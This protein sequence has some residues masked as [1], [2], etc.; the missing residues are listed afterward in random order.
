MFSELTVEENLKIGLMTRNNG[1][2][3]KLNALKMFPRL[4]ERNSQL[5]K[6]LSG[7]ERQMLSL[8]VGL[9]GNPKLLLLDEPTLGLDVISQSKIREFIKHYNKQYNTTFVI[10]S[11]YSKDIQ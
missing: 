5:S 4:K 8:G 1:E 3:T 2:K 6:T 9:M 7:G 11:H 10:S